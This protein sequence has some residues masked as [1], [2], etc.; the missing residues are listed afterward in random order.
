M[1]FTY[2]QGGFQEGRKRF[3]GE[4]ILSEHKLFIKNGA[5]DITQTYIPL[6]KIERIKR[7]G[8]YAD[9][10]VRPSLAYRYVARIHGQKPKIA[11]LVKDIVE[12]RGLKK[13]FLIKEWVEVPE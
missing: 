12:S 7:S 11:E 13:K 6:E 4:I 1:E 10:F 2:G 3:E 8:N 5:D 9:V